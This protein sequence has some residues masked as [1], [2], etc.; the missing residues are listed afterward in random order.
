M[1]TQGPGSPDSSPSEGGQDA[2]RQESISGDFE[3]DVE[4]FGDVDDTTFISR[5]STPQGLRQSLGEITISDMQSQHAAPLPDIGP[6]LE[7][8]EIFVRGFD[9]PPTVQ[10]RD[11]EELRGRIGSQPPPDDQLT[12]MLQ[13]ARW[14]GDIAVD[15][16]HLWCELGPPPNDAED[17]AENERVSFGPNGARSNQLHQSRA[18]SFTESQIEQVETAE[19]AEAIRKSAAEVGVFNGATAGNDESSSSVGSNKEE[20]KECTFLVVYPFRYN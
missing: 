14:N 16:F 13:V 11:R 20:S 1:S 8:T 9:P 18:S 2:T 19:L 12:R 4:D 15:I 10:D 7:T 17:G 3:N 5:C 6:P